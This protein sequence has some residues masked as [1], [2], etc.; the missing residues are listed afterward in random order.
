M[1]LERDESINTPHTQTRCL[2]TAH[3][4][5]RTLSNTLLER[6]HIVHVFINS[7]VALQRQTSQ[8]PLLTFDVRDLNKSPT[9]G[10]KRQ[11]LCIVCATVMNDASNRAAC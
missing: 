4:K 7:T 11:C 8:L 6:G 2:S 3:I 5:L 10:S 1:A 9:L